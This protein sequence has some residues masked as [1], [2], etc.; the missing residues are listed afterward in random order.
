LTCVYIHTVLKKVFVVFLTKIIRAL[1]QQVSFALVHNLLE[2]MKD[3][4]PL[5]EKDGTTSST[6]ARCDRCSS[7]DVDKNADSIQHRPTKGS[8]A[9]RGMPRRSFLTAP[10]PVAEFPARR[11]TNSRNPKVHG[12]RAILNVEPTGRLDVSRD[13][14]DSTRLCTWR[15][16]GPRN[17]SSPAA[18]PSPPINKTHR[19]M[20]LSHLLL[21]PSSIHPLHKHIYRR[22]IQ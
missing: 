8:I 2:C 9:P 14:S 20:I 3:G 16:L 21:L 6:I 19:A 13:Q 18:W 12:A 11:T 7:A 22:S 1:E 10:F 5:Q 15:L 17:A 4:T